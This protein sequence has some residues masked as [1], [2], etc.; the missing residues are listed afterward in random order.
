M[1]TEFK[2]GTSQADR[3]EYVANLLEPGGMSLNPRFEK[4]APLAHAT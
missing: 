4:L 3:R 2:P 1:F